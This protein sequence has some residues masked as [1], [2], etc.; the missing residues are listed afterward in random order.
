MIKYIIVIVENIIDSKD[1]Y[2]KIFLKILKYSS[3]TKKGVS[4]DGR[5]ER[6]DK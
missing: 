5:G 6:R 4:G 3:R 2:L 1:I